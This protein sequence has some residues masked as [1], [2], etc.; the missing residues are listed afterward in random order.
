MNILLVLIFII[1]YFAIA[2]ENAIKINKAASALLTGVLCWT[3]FILCSSDKIFVEHQLNEHLG[4]I[5]SIL[6]FL[7]GAM[8]IVELIDAH[9]GFQII[10]DRIKTRD[11]KTLLW[12]LSIIT[13]FLSAFLDNLTTTIVVVSLIRK[14][15]KNRDDRL[16]YVGITIIAANAGG[17]WS[18][19]GDVTTTMMWIGGQITAG[20]IITHLFLP[21][22]IC[23][24]LPLIF[25][26]FYLK[27]NIETPTTNVDHSDSTDSERA[28]IFFL[29]I[30]VLLFV[31]FFKTITHLP[32]YMGI[33]FG[34]SIMWI[35]TEI[36]HKKKNDRDKSTLSVLHA[37]RKIDTPSILFFLGI[38]ISISALQSANLLTDL[39]QWLAAKIGNDSII[40]ICIG[41]LSSIV[42]NVPLVAATQGM[43]SLNVYPSNHF[44]WLFLTY[45]AGT[46]GSCLIIGS[47]A[48]VAAMGMENIGFFWYLKRI[49]GFA[50]LGFL[51]GAAFFI[52]QYHTFFV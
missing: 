23:L 25:I 8:T 35:T 52:F 20:T 37:L 27:G 40:A 30:G 21:S 36:I 34:L 16:F 17:S 39:A 33:L 9:D 12:L 4:N 24:L 48:G 18:P 15:I 43:Y 7:L 1:G 42:D 5:A 13:F 28:T 41:L 19:I 46:G 45:A 49:A 11:K 38:L 3:V 32:P 44:F 22:L 2:G 14:I 50:L 29:G 31:P 26:S 6:F 10:T 47:A 51:A